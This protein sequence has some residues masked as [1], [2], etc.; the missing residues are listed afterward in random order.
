MSGQESIEIIEPLCAVF[1]RRLKAEGAK[2]TPERAQILDAII[3]HDG[4]FEAESLLEKLN[5]GGRNVSKATVYRTLKLLE[6]AG[7]IQTVL[8]DRDQSHYQ[9]VYGKQP[10]TL[11]VRV[12]TGEI[13][14]VDVPELIALRDR[15]CRQRGLAPEGHRLQ[16]FAKAAKKDA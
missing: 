14:A 5:R 10:Q 7:I 11:I 8:F 12:D 6:E 9:L 13:E 15:I 16:I 3:E 1:R 4:L 2:Y